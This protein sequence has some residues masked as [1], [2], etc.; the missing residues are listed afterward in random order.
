LEE[1]T[2]KDTH[3]VFEITLESW[4]KYV[5]LLWS[6]YL[7]LFR[8]KFS[9]TSLSLVVPYFSGRHAVSDFGSVNESDIVTEAVWPVIMHSSQLCD[10]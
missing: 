4:I 10:W 1:T 5:F 2:T 6:P 7:I 9:P 3:C 8:S